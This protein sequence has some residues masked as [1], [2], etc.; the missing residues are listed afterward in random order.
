ML[1]R[2]QVS[3]AFNRKMCAVLSDG[4]H[5]QQLHV[6][7]AVATISVRLGHHESICT[8]SAM[9]GRAAESVSAAAGSLAAVAAHLLLCP[10]SPLFQAARPS[11]ASRRLRDPV[12]LLHVV[13]CGEVAWFVSVWEVFVEQ[14]WSLLP[15]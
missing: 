11:W 2:V 14:K 13:T 10:L 5:C 8:S 6:V 9:C 4:V 12:F 1:S 7:G 15:G 3:K